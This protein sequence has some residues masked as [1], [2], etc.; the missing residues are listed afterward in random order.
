MMVVIGETWPSNFELAPAFRRRRLCPIPISNRGLVSLSVAAQTTLHAVNHRQSPQG[1]SP[2]R[3]GLAVEHGRRRRKPVGFVV[4]S[5]GARESDKPGR[6]LD[7]YYYVPEGQTVWCCVKTSSLSWPISCERTS[8]GR[9]GSNMSPLFPWPKKLENRHP[10]R[11]SNIPQP[12]QDSVFF[13]LLLA[14]LASIAPYMWNGT[15]L[16]WFPPFVTVCVFLP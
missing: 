5:R 6:H 10:G 9:R 3:L 11:I 14:P 1:P 7:I 4:R 2:V 15:R 13:F 8:N 16:L 12:T